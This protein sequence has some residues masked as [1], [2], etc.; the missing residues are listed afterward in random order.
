M[1]LT[2]FDGPV[3]EHPG[4]RHGCGYR[5]TLQEFADSGAA[6][7]EV[8]IDNPSIESAMAVF[9]G[10]KAARGRHPELAQAVKVKRRGDRVFLERLC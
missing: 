6:S 5:D 9:S 3:P 8:E 10:F 7:A 4:V 2:N 1:K